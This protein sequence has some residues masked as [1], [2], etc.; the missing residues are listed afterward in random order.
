[1]QTQAFLE[2]LA[3]GLTASDRA[4]FN[5]YGESLPGVVWEDG[6]R[7]GVTLRELADRREQE[8]AEMR[9]IDLESGTIVVE[10]DA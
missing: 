9:E 10:R 2:G 1:M 5:P 6:Y 3:A 8:V 4:V 7:I